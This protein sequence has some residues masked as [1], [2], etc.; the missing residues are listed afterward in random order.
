MPGTQ[1]RIEPA[2]RKSR[3]AQGEAKRSR[4][5]AE[6]R[7]REELKQ[8]EERLRQERLQLET[9]LSYVRIAPPELAADSLTRLIESGKVTDHK[10]KIDLLE[11]AFRYASEAQHPVKKTF[12]Y[13]PNTSVDTRSGYLA[14]AYRL[15]LDRLSLQCHVIKTLLPLDRLKARRLFLE[16]STLK[17]E[18]L[19][20]E[21]AL[22]YDVDVFYETAAKIL[23]G[24]FTPLEVRRNLHLEVARRLLRRLSSPAQVAPAAQMVLSLTLTPTQFESLIGDYCEALRKITG[25]SRSFFHRS[26][27]PLAAAEKLVQACQQKGISCAP[28]LEA[29]RDYLVHNLTG[30]RCA[31]AKM[32]IEI[33]VIQSLFDDLRRYSCLGNKEILPLSREDYRPAKVEGQAKPVPYWRSVKARGILTRLQRLRFKSPNQPFREAEKLEAEWQYRFAQ[34]LSDIS[35]WS[36]DEERSEED[37]FHQKCVTYYGLLEIAPNGD[38]RERILLD[39]ITFL[40]GSGLQRSATIE[41]FQH[42][43]RL[44]T[45]ARVSRRDERFRILAALRRSNN[46]IFFL[47]TEMESFLSSR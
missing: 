18:A 22:V 21:E 20:C 38:A 36:E 8:E 33:R 41:W 45:L 44:L 12:T 28:I 39:F 34:V 11:E 46:P 13:L 47:Y 40:S 7:Q 30:S 10:A 1:A 37:Y 27:V 32:E 16:I 9:L 17:L 25:D 2:S 29:L 6:Q 5:T 43:S 24:A 4:D 26:T 14:T 23:A 19:D 35:L 15:D 31:D 42:T 3:E